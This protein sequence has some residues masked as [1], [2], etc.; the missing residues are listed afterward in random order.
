[1]KGSL[2][3]AAKEQG[4]SELSFRLERCVPDI[5]DQYS[6]YKID[7]PYLRK[8]VRYLHA[9]QI[10]LVGEV[11]NE[12]ARPVIADIGDSAGTHLQYIKDIY[13]PGKV[14]RCIGINFD[15][16]AVERIRKRQLE[17]VCVR[18]EDLSS[19]N[20]KADLF[21]CFETLEHLTDPIDFLWKLSSRTDAAYLVATVPYTRKSKV[22]LLHIKRNKKEPVCAE[23]TH[24]FEFSPQDWKLIVKHSGWAIVKEKIYLQY[25][26]KG[27]FNLTKPLWRK[28]DFEGFYGFILK[29]DDSWS[30]K[31]KDWRQ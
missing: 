27:F 8:S 16:K 28:F 10:S 13:G 29:R 6:S 30:S 22:G 9:F 12:L 1:M 20:I 18:A 3:R 21:L 25:P 7:T 31:Y 24:I 26:K 5:T 14:M 17:A 2:E 4:L 11:I 23:N 19:Q 15:L